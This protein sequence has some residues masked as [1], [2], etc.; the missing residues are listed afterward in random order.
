MLQT[1]TCPWCGEKLRG[2][3]DLDPT[4]RRAASLLYCPRG[5]GAD[6]CPFS[7][8]P[9]AGEGLPILTVDEEIYRYAPSLV[10]ATVDKLAQLPWRG[11][12]GHPVRAG[13][14]ALPPARLPA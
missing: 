12:A 3:H 10:I 4:G 8:E 2:H 11:F 7:Q 1:L 6:A 9:V 14:P 5:E 13:A